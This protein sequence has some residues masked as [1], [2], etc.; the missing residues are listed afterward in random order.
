MIILNIFSNLGLLVFSFYNR[1]GTIS[2]FIA[3]IFR[4][5]C[6]KPFYINE[7]IIQFYRIGYKSLPVVGLT[8]FFTGGALAL[9]IFEGGSRFNAQS[10]VP[11]IVAIAMVRELGPVLG[12]LMVAGRVSAA[13]AAEIGTMKVT[14]QLDALRTLS[15][16]PIKYL[17]VPRVIASAISLPLLVAVG[18]TIGIMGGLF[19]GVSRLNFNSSSYLINTIEFLTVDDITSGLFKATVFGFIISIM[20]CFNGFRATKGAEGV[21]R[22]TT[23]AVVS[24]SIIILASNYFLTE[25]LFKP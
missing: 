25:L 18:N 13:L 20:G 22:A 12:G 15:T 10:A 9:Q 5:S 16:D 2:L 6:K 1:V 8:A 24:S 4:L 7:I 3:Q 23:N 21:G 11:S 17:V 14:E 19:V